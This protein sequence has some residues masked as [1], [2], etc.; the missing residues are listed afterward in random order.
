VLLVLGADRASLDPII[1]FTVTSVS[2]N[3][4]LIPKSV[5]GARSRWRPVFLGISGSGLLLVMAFQLPV[6]DMLCVTVCM[7]LAS[8]LGYSTL[9]NIFFFSGLRSVP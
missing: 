1:F 5:Y 4:N 9:Y 7:R 6:L 8:F 3:Y 2:I